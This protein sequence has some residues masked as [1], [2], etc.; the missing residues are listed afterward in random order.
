MSK[1]NTPSNEQREVAADDEKVLQKARAN[2]AKAI[3][4]AHIYP[5]KFAAQDLDRLR[6]FVQKVSD[7]ALAMGVKFEPIDPQNDADREALMKL[8]GADSYNGT[9]RG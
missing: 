4:N 3:I 6:A 9:L 1:V 2:R 5:A 8:I 7:L